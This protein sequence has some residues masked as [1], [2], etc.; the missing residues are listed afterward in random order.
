M[1]ASIH[2]FLA[3]FSGGGARPNRYEVILTFPAAIPGGIAASQKISFTCSAATIPGT[4]IGVVNAPFMGRE[5]KLPG[6][7]TFDDWS[8]T[9]MIDSDFLGRGIFERW[10]NEILGF[11]SNVANSNMVNPINTYA[12]G[13][14]NALSRDDKVIATYEVEGIFPTQVGEIQMGYDQNDQLM[15]Q[16]ITFAINGWRSRNTD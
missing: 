4:T 12:R 13:R 14:I 6:D 2:D 1:T 7:K 5:V 8:V 16:N 15:L 10:H 9:V 3:N 11:R